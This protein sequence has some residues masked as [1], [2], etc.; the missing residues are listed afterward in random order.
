MYASCSPYPSSYAGTKLTCSLRYHNLLPQ[1][2]QAKPASQLLLNHPRTKHIPRCHTSQLAL[3]IHSTLSSFAKRGSDCCILLRLRPAVLY[4]LHSWDG[5][6]VS[7]FCSARA[8]LTNRIN[9]RSCYL[10]HPWMR[11]A[12][13]VGCAVASHTRSP[14]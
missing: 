7:R 12:S 10:R 11:Q 5:V 13:N 3:T 4:C 6:H 2:R 8:E 1:Q 9:S 14:N